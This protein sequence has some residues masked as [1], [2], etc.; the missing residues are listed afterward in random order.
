[1]KVHTVQLT[2]LPRPH[3]RV[4]RL[5][6]FMATIATTDL[7]T[8]LSQ[9][10]YPA[11]SSGRLT[12]ALPGGFVCVCRYLPSIRGPSPAHF[13]YTIPIPY[14]MS[15]GLAGHRV[16]CYEIASNTSRRCQCSP[17]LILMMPMLTRTPAK[18][19]SVLVPN[20]SCRRI[21]WLS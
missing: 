2:K 14:C 18:L 11:H 7:L 20:V 10:T 21:V 13:L 1:V 12:V 19:L 9:I 8:L 15:I 4:H 5:L 17:E 16:T 6:G 3:S